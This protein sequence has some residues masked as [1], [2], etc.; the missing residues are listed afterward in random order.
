MND[1]ERLAWT[2]TALL[3]S[4]CEGC[5]VTGSHASLV[6]HTDVTV[7]CVSASLSVIKK[8]RGRECDA[9]Y[10]L[11]SSEINRF[12][13][14]IQIICGVSNLLWPNKNRFVARV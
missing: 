11:L 6:E 12:S 2:D 13:V 10:R 1:S 9:C 5:L 14:G 8:Q 7:R 3:V 4:L